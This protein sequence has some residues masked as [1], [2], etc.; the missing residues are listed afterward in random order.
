LCTPGVPL[1]RTRAQR[2]DELVEEAVA[3]LE[4]RWSA[5]LADV[6][7]AVLDVPPAATRPEVGTH[8]VPLGRTY[9]AQ[10]ALPPRIVIYRRPIEV[11]ARKDSARKET[12][13]LVHEVVVEQVAELLGLE[14][15]TVDPRY[16]PPE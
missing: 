10:G 3:R 12:A 15:E 8:G 2:F 13:L 7:F 11:R 5:E 16:E 14:P 4:G 1:H 9:P 6:D